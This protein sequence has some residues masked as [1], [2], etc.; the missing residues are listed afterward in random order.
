MKILQRLMKKAAPVL[1]SAPTK[2][3]PAEVSKTLDQ[4]FA[5]QREWMRKRGIKGSVFDTEL[6]P[7]KPLRTEPD[8]VTRRKR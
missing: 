5:V 3:K 1:A 2:V 8:N 7:L 6:K 4:K